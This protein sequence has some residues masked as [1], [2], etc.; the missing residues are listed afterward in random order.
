VSASARD[1]GAVDVAIIWGDRS[2]IRAAAD[3]WPD[4]E[5]N[6]QLERNFAIMQRHVNRGDALLFLQASDPWL[7]EGIAPDRVAA[8]RQ[9]CCEHYGRVAPRLVAGATN[10]T[11]APAPTAEWAT[12]VFEGSSADVALARLWDAVFAACRI[13][14]ANPIAAWRMH[15][16]AL[17]AKQK[18]IDA[19]R[20]RTLRITGPGTD[21]FVNLVEDHAWCTAALSTEEGHPFVANLP[22][23]EIFTAPDRRSARGVVRVA[24]PVA[25][26]GA[27]IDGIELE[28]EH[29]RVVSSRAEKGEMLLRRVLE[30]D[31][32]ASHLG[33]IALIPGGTALARDR[34]CFFHPLL[35]ENVLDHIALGDAYPFTVQRPNPRTLNRSLIHIDLPLEATV[36]FEA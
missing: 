6:R 30:T 21:L 16:D 34:T 33:E 1:A 8:L 4:R 36:S 32:G 35:D 19:R 20:W 5:F 25:W 27:V 3:A 31:E 26:G 14:T 9:R 11:A 22:T 23:D 2:R 12:A 7:M 28:F 15:L 10:W 29:G 24:R 18:D 17:R 13:D